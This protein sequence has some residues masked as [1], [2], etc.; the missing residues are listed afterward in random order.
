MRRGAIRS[1]W[2]DLGGF[3]WAFAGMVVMTAVATVLLGLLIP[4]TIERNLVANRVDALTGIIEE[5]AAQG[6]LPGDFA[7]QAELVVLDEW[8]RQRL[9]GGELARVKV[10]ATSGEL[11]YSDTPGLPARTLSESGHFLEALGGEVPVGNPDL[12]RPEHE[13]ER[14]L[15]D[16]V[17][18][19][20]P[21]LDGEG[22]T[23]AVME[24]Y[25]DATPM[26]STVESVR[27]LTSIA[28]AL[29]LAALGLGLVTITIDHARALNK[30]VRTAE[31]RA[32]ELNLAQIEER[33]RIVGALHDDIGQPLYRVLYGIQG[34]RSRLSPGRIS[35]EL[36]SLEDLIR[37]IDTTLKTELRLLHT[38]STTSAIE[39]ELGTLLDELVAQVG[40]ETAL[41]VQLE[42]SGHGEIAPAVGMTLFR[43]ARE[44]L[45]NAQRHSAA[46][47]IRVRLFEGNGRLVLDVEDDGEGLPVE[48]GLGLIT[49]R[50]RL[51]AIGGGISVSSRPGQGTL[52]RAWVPIEESGR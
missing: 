24:V 15:G 18:F 22:D 11:L 17:E 7:T 33:K 10:W 23:V 16:L 39:N 32:G 28:S 1:L 8:V 21:I 3:R 30:R 13:F 46:Q 6:A 36:A 48:P 41:D 47:R 2:N 52:F 12:S 4:A 20:V 27:G 50:E 44:G 25:Q 35:N 29:V 31:E 9:P 37:S 26:A 5:L 49:T 34:A 45:T 40:F 38:D 51:E 19:Y 42:T 14:G 43:A